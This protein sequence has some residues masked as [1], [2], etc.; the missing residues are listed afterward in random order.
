LVKEIKHSTTYVDGTTVIMAAQL[1]AAHVIEDDTIQ[2]AHVDETQ[3]FTMKGLTLTESLTMAALKTVD[4]VDVSVHDAATMGVHGV[5]AGT[6]AKVADIAT[7]TNLS[8]VA[9]AAIAAVQAD[10]DQA[11]KT[12]SKPSFAGVTLTSDQ[13]NPVLTAA[14]SDTPV[15]GTVRFVRLGA[16]Q[17]RI[18]I[19]HAT[20][21]WQWFHFGGTGLQWWSEGVPYP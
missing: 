11:V 10:L 15:A 9:Q 4:G 18:Y 20:D 12:S 21:G 5:G 1:N 6:V 13:V 2:P 17:W 14:P 7:D 16:N 19:Y 8:A 3:D